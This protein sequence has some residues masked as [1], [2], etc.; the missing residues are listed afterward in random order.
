MSMNYIVINNKNDFQLIINSPIFIDKQ[1]ALR[2]EEINT[3]MWALSIAPLELKKMSLLI[4]EQFV[5]D[6][7][8]RRKQQVKDAHI[9]HSVLFYMWF[10]KMASQ[11]R[12]NIISDHNKKL[13]FGCN[14]HIVDSVELIL[15][16]FLNAERYISWNELSVC[17]ED[18]EDEEEYILDVFV[19]QLSTEEI[20]A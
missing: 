4:M 12:F 10:D 14:L 8:L 5:Q 15:E 18:E 9:N 3:N 13:P 2:Q 19:Q 1:F 20:E 7:I 6:L 11:L 17:E 16:E